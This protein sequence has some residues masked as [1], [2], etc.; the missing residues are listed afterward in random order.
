MH[1]QLCGQGTDCQDAV[2]SEARAGAQRARRGHIPPRPHYAGLAHGKADGIA[3]PR[4][5]KSF[6]VNLA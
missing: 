6:R 1:L 3:L 5:G 4:F 2:P